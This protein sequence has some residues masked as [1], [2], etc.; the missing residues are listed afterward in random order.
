PEKRSAILHELFA[1]DRND[2]GTSYIR[3]S[4]GASDMN[5]HVFSYDDLPEGQTDPTLA[6]FSLDPDRADVIPILKQIL[7]IDSKIKILA[8]P[9]SAPSWMKTN[10][11]VKGGKLR[12]EYYDA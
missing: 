3:V 8:S 10:N 7:S 4:V 9:W 6:R 5:D 12:P 1:N 11:N 2:I